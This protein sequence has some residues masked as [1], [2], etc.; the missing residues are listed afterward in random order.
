MDCG[1]FV[2][3]IKP[4]GALKDIIEIYQSSSEL[5]LFGENITTYINQ[6]WRS[7]PDRILEA[8]HLL[9]QH[10]PSVFDELGDEHAITISTL[11]TESFG[12]IHQSEM[13][14]VNPSQAARETHRTPMEVIVHFLARI[15]KFKNEGDH[16][17]LQF[18]S[19]AWQMVLQ[20]KLSCRNTLQFLEKII[21]Y[22]NCK[23]GYS[24]LSFFCKTL[25][26]ELPKEG[27]IHKTRLHDNIYG[28]VLDSKIVGKLV[29]NPPIGVQQAMTQTSRVLGSL[30]INMAHLH[31]SKIV[32]KLKLGLEGDLRFW[33]PRT[34]LINTFLKT[35]PPAEAFELLIK[36]LNAEKISGE[37]CISIPYML[38]KI[39]NVLKEIQL[40]SDKD[41]YPD[42][43]SLGSSFDEQCIKRE[44][45]PARIAPWMLKC[46]PNYNHFIIPQGCRVLNNP[47]RQVSDG[48]GITLRN[49]P[50]TSHEPWMVPSYRQST[51]CYPDFT[52]IADNEALATALEFG[53]PWSSG[54]SGSLNVILF[55]LPLILSEARDQRINLN[56]YLLASMMFLV[57][58]GGHSIQEVL[59]TAN[60]IDQRLKFGFHLTDDGEDYRVFIAD[61]IKFLD[62][63]RGTETFNKLNTAYTSAFDNLTQYF[64]QHS[65]FARD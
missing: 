37:E 20:H 41:L 5:P 23:F 17:L 56:D 4:E 57:H 8:S 35:K 27:T 3:S 47:Q 14:K 58:D 6:T 29:E 34:P 19:E 59:W 30:L 64:N 48:G 40:K 24:E 65:Y 22:C 9:S 10:G 45:L 38:V 54:V 32:E 55:A 16:N 43:F 61:Y 36:Y 12:K 62:L 1:S 42:I 49:Q 51:G 60:Q 33:F 25:H 7:N 18:R 46:D 44:K 26:D 31:L 2:S 11:V 13:K 15:D 53:A 21:R 63:F 52:K 28:R 39:S 50:S